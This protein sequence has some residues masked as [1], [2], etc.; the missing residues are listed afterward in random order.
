MF[1]FCYLTGG[2]RNVNQHVLSPSL[3]GP[4]EWPLM[5]LLFLSLLMGRRL[6]ECVILD[7]FLQ[8]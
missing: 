7:E 3:A 5:L 4:G 8:L 1:F 2:C 6:N